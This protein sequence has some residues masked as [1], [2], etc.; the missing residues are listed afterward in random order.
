[1]AAQ[2]QYLS[3][4]MGVVTGRSLPELVRERSNRSVRL[5]YWAQAEL[6]AMA[7]DLAEVV[8]GAIALQLLFRLPLVVGGV[9]VGLVSMALLAV[10][11][12]RG[13]KPFERMIIGL[14]AVISIGFMASLVIS[15][16]PIGRMVGGLLPRFSGGD[17]VLLAA[18]IV[19]AT[20]MPHVIYLHS[21]L[22]RD[23]HGSPEP[24]PARARL[25]RVNRWD[26]GLAMVIAG[27]VNLAMLLM[28]AHTFGGRGDIQTIQDAHDAVRSTLG[29]VAALLLSIGLL[30]SGLAST[31][32]G[33][34]A[35][36]MIMEGL[37]RRRIPLLLRRTLTL[38]PALVLLAV[39]LDATRILIVSQVAL[40][41]AIP[42]ALIPLVRF[43]GDRRLMGADRN[44]RL[45]TA[46]AWVVAAIIVA[47]NLFLI[48][49]T[50]GVG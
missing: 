17:S 5:A 8:G 12:R 20:V 6:A 34:Y 13:Q 38:I 23:R 22:S 1:M 26:V 2:V 25:L 44:H 3:A 35:G 29:P 27:L 7:T 36:A 43:T 50:L 46:S 48:A 30:A 40:S 14:L 45:T 11:N 37:L 39:G 4:K 49:Q 10:Q 42:F 47:L 9:I 41:F 32:V 16:P 33:A 15:P 24:G 28:A 31:S 21:G 18:A 19:G